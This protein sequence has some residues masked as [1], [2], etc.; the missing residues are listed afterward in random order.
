MGVFFY[1][2]RFVT[3]FAPI[4]GYCSPMDFLSALDELKQTYKMTGGYPCSAGEFLN[5][6]GDKEREA[7]EEILESRSLPVI[8]IARLADKYG[9]KV[10]TS[11][12]YK[13]RVKDCR[14]FH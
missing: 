4:L 13:H 8:E 6:I 10:S 14:C 2:W 1:L 11:Q 9:Y 12:L 3:D 7:V 5:K